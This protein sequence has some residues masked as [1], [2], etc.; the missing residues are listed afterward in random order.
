MRDL[1]AFL[2]HRDLSLPLPVYS[3]PDSRFCKIFTVCEMF[4]NCSRFPPPWKYPLP[5]LPLP[6]PPHPEAVPGRT[7]RLQAGVV[8]AT[9]CYS[10]VGRIFVL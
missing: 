3:I 9:I 4:R 8:Q 6:I 7:E 1:Q 5:P 2:V 10:A